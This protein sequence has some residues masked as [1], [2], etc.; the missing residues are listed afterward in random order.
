M[1][2]VF[3]RNPAIGPLAACKHRC[4]KR[5]KSSRFCSTGAAEDCR[6]DRRAGV[7]LGVV[8]LIDGVLRL[9]DGAAGQ[10]RDVEQN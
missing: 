8:L 10:D 2:H 1:I 5:F 4:K 6:S 9:L 3:A 7:S